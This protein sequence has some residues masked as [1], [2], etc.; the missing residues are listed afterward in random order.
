[1]T[2]DNQEKSRR[3]GQNPLSGINWDPKYYWIRKYKE[4]KKFKGYQWGRTYLRL[5]D[6]LNES[7]Y[8]QFVI[9]ERRIT[10]WKSRL[11][12]E[13]EKGG[14]RKLSVEKF[15]NDIL[16]INLGSINFKKRMEYVELFLGKEW[17]D[18]ISQ[19]I[20]GLEKFME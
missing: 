11:I 16:K 1:M 5:S 20:G 4:L 15:L 9:F 6:D 17:M 14:N 2:L 19:S 3:S 12:R 18:R 8:E 13:Y 7:N 10:K